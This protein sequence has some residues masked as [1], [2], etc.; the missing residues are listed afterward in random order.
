MYIQ[1][2]L[3]GTQ[4]YWTEEAERALEEYEGGQEDAV[5]RYLQVG[6][7]CMCVY[8][9]CVCVHAW[10]WSARPMHSSSYHQTCPNT[11]K[12]RSATPASPR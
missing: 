1:V 4:I 9:A 10:P 3:T 5:K 8:F 11:P 6:V 7:F 2:V 12:Q